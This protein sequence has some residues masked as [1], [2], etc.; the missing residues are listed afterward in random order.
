MNNCKFCNFDETKYDNLI[1]VMDLPSGALYLMADQ[2]LPGRCI[3]AM[4]RHVKKLTELTEQ[5][6]RIFFEDVRKI[7]LAINT[8][9]SPDKINYLVL[10]DL[11]DHLHIHI[12][13]KYREKA[14]W[15][16]I[17][18]MDREEYDVFPLEKKNKISDSFRKLL[19]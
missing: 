17:F 16:K 12:V 13:P 2:T 6:Y 10:G 11:S 5:E 19:K 15:G 9:F 1:Y 14:E 3:L 8:L 7:A 4:G 18:T